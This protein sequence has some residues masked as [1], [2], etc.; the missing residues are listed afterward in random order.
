[1]TTTHKPKNPRKRGVIREVRT[2]RVDPVLWRVA[3]QTAEDLGIPLASIVERQLTEFVRSART[4][5]EMGRYI[6]RLPRATEGI[7]T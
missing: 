3:A 5:E 4:P 2:I 7:F 1:M 6:T